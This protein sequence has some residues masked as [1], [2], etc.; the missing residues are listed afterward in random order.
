MILMNQ[1]SSGGLN[2]TLCLPMPWKLG[3]TSNCFFGFA[4]TFLI[5]N[6]QSAKENRRGPCIFVDSKTDGALIKVTG[7]NDTDQRQNWA[8]T[9]KGQIM[10]SLGPMKRTRCE[11][12]LRALASCR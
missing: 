10:V 5:E 2:A 11:N 4:E 8:Y 3:L 12:V 7:C 6:Q 1:C 9:P